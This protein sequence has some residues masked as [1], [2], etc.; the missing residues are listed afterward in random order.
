LIDPYILVAM[1]SSVTYVY[2]RT[3]YS[4]NVGLFAATMTCATP[5]LFY[6]LA[7]D[8]YDGV[9]ATSLMIAQMLSLSAW[10]R[11]I[12][13]VAGLFLAIASN[14]NNPRSSFLPAATP[15]AAPEA[16]APAP[17]PAPAPQ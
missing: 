16:P 11:P 17:S 13:M 12:M 5:W 14:V 4:A 1:A 8:H 7:S 6:G 10:R 15:A 9:A 3:N 2:G